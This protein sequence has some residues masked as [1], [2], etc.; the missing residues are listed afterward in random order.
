MEQASAEAS[1]AVL[2]NENYAKA[3]A[4]RAEARLKVRLLNIG[5]KHALSATRSTPCMLT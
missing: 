3:Y 2:R 1:E 4:L 5:I